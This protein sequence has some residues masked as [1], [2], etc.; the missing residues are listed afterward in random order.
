MRLDVVDTN[1]RAARFYEQ[2]GFV[3]DRTPTIRPLVIFRF[4][5][6]QHGAARSTSSKGVT[7]T[8]RAVR[9]DFFQ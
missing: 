4:N 5:A 2:R 9:A 8:T 3:V 1:W 7:D 6:A